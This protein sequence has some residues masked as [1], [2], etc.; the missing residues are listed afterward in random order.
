MSFWVS[1]IMLDSDDSKEIDQV[2]ALNKLP[3]IPKFRLQKCKAFSGNF[4]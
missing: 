2:P 4:G 1:D 3:E